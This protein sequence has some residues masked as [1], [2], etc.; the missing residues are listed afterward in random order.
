M[1][2]DCQKHELHKLV[3]SYKRQN[4]HFPLLKWDEIFIHTSTASFDMF[5]YEAHFVLCVICAQR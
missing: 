3:V 2:G 1:P 5:A 4:K